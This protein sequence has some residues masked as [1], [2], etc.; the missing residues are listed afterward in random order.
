M[1]EFMDTW[2]EDIVGKNL[3]IMIGGL[4]SGYIS[5]KHLW[6]LISHFDKVT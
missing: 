4:I 6:I 3:S 5:Q 1:V 2:S